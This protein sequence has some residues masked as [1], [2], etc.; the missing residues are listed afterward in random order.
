MITVTADRA[1][2]P[3]SAGISISGPLVTTMRRGYEGRPSSS[4]FWNAFQKP[5][6]VAQPEERKA[7]RVRWSPPDT[8]TARASPLGVTPA[9]VGAEVEFRSPGS[10]G[11]MVSGTGT[12]LA[13]A[14]SP[15]P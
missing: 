8:V 10:G 13:P 3:T 14:G 9:M 7:S 15:R 1:W 11:P 6:Q 12:G 4:G 2:E 5:A